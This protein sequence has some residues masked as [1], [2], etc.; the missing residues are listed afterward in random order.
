V[1]PPTQDNQG[2]PGFRVPMLVI[3]PYVPA[4]EISQ[5]VY[6][7]GSIIKFVEDTFK[8]KC[9]G[10]TDC[11]SN[12]IADMFNFK[13]KARAFKAIKAKYSRA[14]FLHQ[15]ASELPVDTQ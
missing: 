4:G 1:A 6:G 3:S 2:G 7:F 15:K 8:L 5:T 12:S 11:S 9:L 10:T 13:Q 14:Y